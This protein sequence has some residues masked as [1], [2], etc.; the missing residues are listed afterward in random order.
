MFVNVI[1]LYCDGKSPDCVTKGY[2]ANNADGCSEIK[3]RAEYK[4]EKRKEGWIFHPENK[5][6]CPAC[7]KE[8]KDN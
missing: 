8:M 2:E 4:A 1:Y 5:A 7:Q 6:Y 3:T